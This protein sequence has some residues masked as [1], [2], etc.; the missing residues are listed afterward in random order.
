MAE[1]V[2]YFVHIYLRL[3]KRNPLRGACSLKALVAAENHTARKALKWPDRMLRGI[4]Q[5]SCA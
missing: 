3:W 1:L 4:S 2:S 5:V